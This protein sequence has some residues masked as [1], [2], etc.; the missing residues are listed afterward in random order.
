MN[1]RLTST[2][3]QPMALS[4]QAVVIMPFALKPVVALLSDAFPIAGYHKLPYVAG[5]PM[6]S[7][8]C[9]AP[10]PLAFSF[11]F[12]F[13]GGGFWRLPFPSKMES[14]CEQRPP[15]HPPLEAKRPVSSEA[16]RS[17]GALHLRLVLG[18]AQLGLRPGG[19]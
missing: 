9:G 12:V 18:A 6:A 17:R 3:P 2:R 16:K 10:T 5:G 11:L 15:L 8:I 19:L 1:A 4:R 13:F 7:D 14:S